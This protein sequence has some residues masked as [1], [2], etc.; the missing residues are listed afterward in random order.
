MIAEHGVE[1]LFTA[2]TAIRAIKK[3]DPDGAL[4]AGHDLSRVPHAVPGRGAARP[5]HLPLGHRAARRP[6]RRQLVADRDRL[7][8]R[9]EPARPRADA[10]QGRARRRSRCPGYQVEVLGEQGDAGRRP[11]EEGAICLRLPLP[12]G[13]LTDA[14]GRRR[15]VR[16]RRTS[17]PSRATTSPATAATSTRTATSS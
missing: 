7:A 14:V 9:G 15:A 8:D 13:T 12:P 10:D 4:L 5:G 2:P 16:R 11:G 3:E 1:A 17:R 6:G